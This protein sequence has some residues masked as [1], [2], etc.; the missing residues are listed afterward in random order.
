MSFNPNEHL[1]G[2][3]GNTKYLQV[4][5]RIVWMREKL[6]N[7]SIDTECIEHDDK[8]AKFRATISNDGVLLATAHGSETVNDFKDFFEKAET[9]AIGRALA[10]CGFGTQFTGDEL[11]E[12]ERIVDSPVKPGIKDSELAPEDLKRLNTPATCTRCGKEITETTFKDKKYG[13]AQIVGM[14]KKNFGDIYCM[15]CMQALKNH[16]GDK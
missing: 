9:K 14:S 13:A 8:H 4:M 7:A 11:D 10:L 1:I 2:L 15:D 16:G 6:P 5:W 3:K 12:G